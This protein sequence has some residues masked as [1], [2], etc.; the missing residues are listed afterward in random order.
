MREGGG[1]ILVDGSL[2]TGKTASGARTSRQAADA[3]GADVFE[4]IG[5]SEA[6][7]STRPGADIVL[8]R[9]FRRASVEPELDPMNLIVVVAEEDEVARFPAPQSGSA[10][11]RPR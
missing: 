1:L 6:V 9:G 3:P 11:R 8:P 5:D 10:A 2:T 4:P 7:G